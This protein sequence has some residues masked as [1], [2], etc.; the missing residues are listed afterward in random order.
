MGEAKRK[1]EKLG[2]SKQE[3]RKKAEE[4]FFSELYLIHSEENPKTLT[5]PHSKNHVL[6][7]LQNPLNSCIVGERLSIKKSDLDN[8]VVVIDRQYYLDSAIEFDHAYIVAQR[9]YEVLEKF[10]L[11]ENADSEEIRKWVEQH[12]NLLISF[13]SYILQLNPETQE[14]H[15]LIYDPTNIEQYQQ[16]KENPFYITEDRQQQYLETEFLM[17]E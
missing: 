3:Y 5:I 16:L 9:I 8:Y 4:E 2:L 13:P 10:P 1:R 6:K 14:S 7:L 11:N 12:S 15:K 17:N